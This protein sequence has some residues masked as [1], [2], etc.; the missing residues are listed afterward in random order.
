MI[1]DI[2][3]VKVIQFEKLARYDII[4]HGVSTRCAGVSTGIFSSMNLGFHRGD[5]TENV[6]ENFRIISKALDMPYEHMVLSAQTHTTNIRVVTKEDMGK[7][8]VRERDY[9]DVDGLITNLPQIPLVTFYAD[10]VPL[11]F[12][13]PVKRVIGASHSGWRG[14]VNRMAVKTV[15]KLTVE[16]GCNPADIIA[17]IGPSI[18]RSCYEVDAD[19]ANA[20]Q[21]EFFKQEPVVFEKGE[22]KYL[23]DL[24]KANQLLLE[25]A[26][27]L[28][29]HIENAGICTC[30]HPE[31][32]FSH[33]AS[34]GKRGNLAAFLMLK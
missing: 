18:C 33:R 23:V 3:T 14:T 2:G 12:F 22:G 27:V 5:S 16:F 30:C 7:G 32:L 4:K 29:A 1:T 19:V 25:S 21:T 20:F 10:C 9:E 11:L 31:L 15:E 26:G 17:C 34:G 13:D 6:L 24:Q 8:I 28:E